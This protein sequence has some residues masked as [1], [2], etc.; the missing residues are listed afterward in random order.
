MAAAQIA[1]AEGPLALLLPG[2]GA[3]ST[4]LIAGVELARKGLAKPIGSL[5]QLGTIRL[6]K[7]TDN[8]TPLVREF[9]PLARIDDLVFGAWDIFPDTCYQ[10]ARKA[11]VLDPVQ[12]DQVRAEMEAI[13]PWPAAFD[14]AYVKRLDGPHVK[15]GASKLA[16][17]EQ[18]MGDIE[19]F[20]TRAGASRLVMI[21]CGSTESFLHSQDVHR[22]LAAFEAGLRASHP[23]IAPSMLYAY[24]ALQLGIPFANGAPNLTVDIPA[25]VELAN[26]RGV[27]IAGKDFKTGQTLMKT[28]IAP[29]LKARML[30]LKG[31]FS[32][33]I[34]GNRDGEVLDEPSAFRTKEES[35]LSVL[36]VILRQDLHPELYGDYV[37]RVSIHYYPPRGDNKEGWDNIDVFGWLG[38]PMQIK[39]NF[40]C[41]DSILAAPLV[42]DLALFLDLAQRAGMH[43]VQ[44]WLSFYFKSPQTAPGLYPEHDL[45]IQLMKLKNT[46]RYLRG[47]ELITHLG[48]E[49]Y[50]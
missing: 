21:W 18:I 39:I 38:Y 43:G 8:R 40:L 9:V 29:G 24:A 20:R 28:I 7:R 3:V 49:Y 17:A 46:L 32:T 23:A 34:L 2:L 41:R 44:E 31:W 6:G 33:N 27:P 15:R 4:T 47:E 13:A 16:L 11:G 45:F 36:D 12:L 26:T 35:K 30:G 1:P 42:L 37:H 10:S 48:L 19:R 25:L 22:S 5:T 50:D 14:P